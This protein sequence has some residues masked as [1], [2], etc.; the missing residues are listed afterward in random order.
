[1][2]GPFKQG[3]RVPP[4]GTFV[5]T[6]N[7]LGWPTTAGVWLYHDHS[8]CDMDNV[9]HGAISIIVIHNP[10]DAE[11]EVDIRVANDP[12]NSL[13][14]AFL[15]NGTLNAPPIE[16]ICFPIRFPFPF[17]A[18]V[19]P[20]DLA[21]LGMSGRLSSVMPGMPSGITPM[22]SAALGVETLGAM[23]KVGKAKGA[24][25]A[26]T[27][28]TETGAEL[29]RPGEPGIGAPILAR[30]IKQGNLLLE[31]D[32]KLLSVIRL[33]FRFY[34]KPASKA[35]YLQLY[36]T[37]GAA[38]VSINGRKYLGNTPT[39]IARPR[40]GA[41]PG[42]KMRFGV[43]G[44][45]SLFH[46]FH[47]HGHRWILPGPT[48]TTLAS[49]Q[50]SVQH[51]PVS[52]FEDTRAFGPANSF[53]F[54]IDEDS[55]LPSFFRSEPSTAP[56]PEPAIGEW[57]MHCHL[58]DHMMEGMMGSLLVVTAGTVANPLPSATLVCPDDVPRGGMPGM[59]G[60][61]A[62]K[63]VDAVDDNTNPTGFSFKPATLT[64]NKGD[65]V[66]FKNT[67]TDQHGIAWD[68]AGAPPNTGLFGPG[69]ST[70]VVMS[71][72]GTFNYHCFVH[73]AQMN[74]QITVNP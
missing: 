35:L 26:A 20:H 65:T 3:D 17:G 18:R 39:L 28:A 41:E 47:L 49:I 25:P 1:M 56:S 63:E 22:P 4:G 72:A 15:P 67:S 70:S 45:G 13:D 6:W 32:E 61:P 37:L 64:V 40:Q 57:H 29:A 74:G 55:G 54:T 7:T 24:K 14:P 60:G 53:V 30:T 66:V 69:T 34:V 62:T 71:N 51:S 31:L 27:G 38:G 50:T 73:G 16:T 2:S 68:T 10:N 44:M 58:L 46:T 19:L 43:V 21:A 52:Q 11:N 5:Y 59:G 9:E 8:V 36:H 33:C 23:H 12:D 42:T 48:G